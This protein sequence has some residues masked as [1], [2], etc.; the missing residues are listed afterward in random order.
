MSPSVHINNKSKD[1]LI[2]CE[3][4]TQ[5]LDDTKSTAEAKFPFK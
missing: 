4:Q 5:A 1:I 3:G 2:I